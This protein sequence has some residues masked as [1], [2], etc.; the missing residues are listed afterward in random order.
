[1]GKGDKKSKRG[2]IVNK[3]YGVRRPRKI[4]KK[5]SVEDKVGVKSKT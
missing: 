1:M 3:T 4:K 2:K 5:A